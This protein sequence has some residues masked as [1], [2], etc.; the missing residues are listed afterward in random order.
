MSRAAFQKNWQN[1]IR[2]ILVD[3]F[4]HIPEPSVQAEGAR[5]EQAHR[6]IQEAAWKSSVVSGTL[7]LPVGPLGMLTVLPDLVTVWKIQSQ[8]VVNVAFLHGKTVDRDAMIYCLFV[9]GQSN[10]QDFMIR[11]VE[12]AA[13]RAGRRFLGEAA[14]RWVPLVGA[15]A[16]G[17]YVRRDTLKVG[18]NALRLFAEPSF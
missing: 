3:I 1:Q 10:M 18:R 4:T 15:L 5:G 9:Q 12:R 6:V 16:V 8:M 13:L 14:A 7:S 2:E 17:R 11:A